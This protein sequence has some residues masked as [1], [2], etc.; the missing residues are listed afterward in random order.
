M[1]SDLASLDTSRVELQLSFSYPVL[2]AAAFIYDPTAGAIVAFVGTVDPRELRREIT[3]IN[4]L[5]NRCQITLSVM[6]ASTVFHSMGGSHLRWPLVLGVGVLALAADMV[7][8]AILVGAGVR[9]RHQV[10]WRSLAESLVMG[11]PRYFVVTYGLYGLSAVIFRELFT[12]YGFWAFAAF[13]IPIVLGHEV[14]AHGERLSQT[15][16]ELEATGKALADV[17]QAIAEERR[18]ERAKVAESLHDEIL[19]QLHHVHLMGEVLRHDLAS[20]RLLDLEHDL[21]ELLVATEGAAESIRSVIRDLRSSS[22]GKGG[23]T[24]TVGLLVEELTS[25][26]QIPIEAELSDVG[27]SPQIQLLVYQVAREALQ[28]AVKHSGARNIRVQLYRNGSTI[29]LNVQDD[30][31]GFVLRV[32]DRTQHFGL[33]LMKERLN[34]VGGRLEIVSSK[35]AGTRVS[36]QFPPEVRF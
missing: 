28:N 18:D 7:V 27:G 8:N 12:L 11:R 22:V 36:A 3:L 23:L 24:P 9:L 2:L 1:I 29:H 25:R 21:P 19:Q 17:S 10:D 20:G 13:A 16:L 33:Q 26:Y 14:F 34:M 5:F 30:G 31:C 15:T 4:G 35:G 6:A 32:V